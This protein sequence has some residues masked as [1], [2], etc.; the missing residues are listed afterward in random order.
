LAR[1]DSETH[2]QQGVADFRRS[3]NLTR[4]SLWSF[5]T[6]GHINSDALTFRQAHHPRTLQRR[7]MHKKYLCQRDPGR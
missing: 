7:G 4:V 2:E 1:N 5:L 6:I 3:D